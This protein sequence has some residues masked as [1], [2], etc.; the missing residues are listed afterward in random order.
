M[1]NDA[2]ATFAINLEG[3]TEGAAAAAAN[4]L[5][6]LRGRLEEDTKALAAMQR[7]MKNLQQGTVVPI[8]QA[9]QLRAAIASKKEAVAAAQSQYLALGGSFTRTSSSGSRFAAMMKQA[10]GMPGPLSAVV[11]KF[12]A[13]K[14]AV[15][16]GAIAVG[17]IGI[18][19]ALATLVVATA[20]AVAS[21][22]KYGIAQADARRSELLRLEGLTKLRN[23]WGVAAGNA[24]ELQ[25]MID[26][27]SAS[28]A[29]GR[30]KIAGYAEQ[31][32]RMN[33]R[34]QN[35][36]AALEAVSIKASTQGDAAAGAFAQWAAGAN[37][38]GGSVKRLADDVK[39]RLGG[40]AKAQ[41]LSLG[42]QTEKQHEAFDML[43]E[44]LKIE[45]FL[46][47]LANLRGLL[48]QNTESGRGLK[49]MLTAMIQPFI[50]G[51]TAAMPVFK[52][53]FQG[54]IIGALH[55]G[56]VILQLRNWFLK[57]FG[58]KDILSGFD[59]QKAALKA[60]EAAFAVF[61]AGLVIVGTL[62][63]GIALSLATIAGV[64]AAPFILGAKVIGLVIEAGESLYQ[65]WNAIDWTSL[66]TSIWQGIVEGVTA[67]AEWVKKA[68]TDL[69]DSAWKG[70]KSKLGI[71]S[72]SRVFAEL[73]LAIPAGVGVGV[74]A[75]TPRVH[76]AVD[77]MVQ[78]PAAVA[79]ASPRL[80]AAAVAAS[81]APMLRAAAAP[82]QPGY[83]PAAPRLEPLLPTADRGA[84]ES[85]PSSAPSSSAQISFG[86]IHVHAQS[87][88]P[89][90]MAK[91]LRDELARIL[92]GV[93]IQLGAPA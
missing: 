80:G 86:D 1:A 65:F 89:R 82:M 75:G 77:R 63:A 79:V 22:A 55:L 90:T 51:A 88:D 42:V 68:L 71:S 70:F 49:A 21:L 91:E 27:V 40:V 66:G 92:Q 81:P 83:A 33:L 73:G 56:I 14:A 37:M 19:A 61:A 34:G 52:R 45:S 64:I 36:S 50:N 57:T 12:E 53:F 39:A 38:A 17:I 87:G 62:L 23:W 78:E 11:S 4:A 32:Y 24:G 5:K 35:L 67:G 8:Q 15:G 74:E 13:F 48:T 85:A 25:G 47:A 7:A 69:G 31:L 72:P 93:N 76:R 58:A 59:L 6:D 44:G 28:S 2:Q 43:F 46:G 30:D 16:G 84:P 29:L 3:N 9:Q 10:Q 54:L 26:R 60:G 41:M 20:A 18:V